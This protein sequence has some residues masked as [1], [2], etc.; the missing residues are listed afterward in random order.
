V[1]QSLK[2]RLSRDCPPGDPSH[3]KTPNPDPISEAK[4]YLLTGVWY[5]CLL[6]GSTRAWQIQRQMLAVNHWTEHGVPNGGVKER[7]EGAE[8]VCNPIGRLTISTN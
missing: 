1:E 7:I 3:I 8:E 2:E 4:K 5:S 6:T